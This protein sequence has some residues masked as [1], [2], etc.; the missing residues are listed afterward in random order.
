[1]GFVSQTK[2]NNSHV[3]GI[4]R[5]EMYAATIVMMLHVIQRSVCADTCKTN[6]QNVYWGVPLFGQT[7]YNV[8]LL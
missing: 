6:K 1:M 7:D 2:Q 4:I 3:Y 5:R 8:C